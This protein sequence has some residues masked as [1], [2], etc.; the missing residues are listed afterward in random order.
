MPGWD[1]PIDVRTGRPIFPRGLSIPPQTVAACQRLVDPLVPNT[2]KQAASPVLI[3]GLLRF[4]GCMRSHGVSDWPDPSSDG[5]FRPDARIQDMPQWQIVNPLR[6]CE[7]FYPNSHGH[8]DFG[9]P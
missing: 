7:R 4:A 1:P 9:T 5:T 3:A 8:V 2:Q 6:A